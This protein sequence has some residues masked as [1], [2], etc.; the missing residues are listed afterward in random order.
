MIVCSFSD[1]D[2]AGNLFDVGASVIG[3]VSSTVNLQF[4]SI[5][6]GAASAKMKGYIFG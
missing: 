5:S 3:D 6:Y 2:R 1:S 4:R